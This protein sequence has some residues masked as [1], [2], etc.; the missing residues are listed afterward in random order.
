MLQKCVC[1][2]DYFLSLSLSNPLLTLSHARVQWHLSPL[3][4]FL[5]VGVRFSVQGKKR[6][7]YTCGPFA[8]EIEEQC[9]PHRLV[10]ANISHLT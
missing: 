10:D 8:P 4:L 9:W 7:R 5:N 1:W 2:L 3:K 6:T